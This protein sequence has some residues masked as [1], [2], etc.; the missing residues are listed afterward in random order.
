MNWQWSALDRFTLVSNSDAHSPQ[1]LGREA[2]LFDTDFS[3]DGLFNALKSQEGFLGTYEFFPEEGKYHLDGHRACGVTLEPKDTIR[4]K[5][6]C[7]VCGRPLTVGVL[8]RVEE[9]SDRPAPQKPEGSAGYEYLIPLPEILAE[10]KG[11]GPDSKAVM[12]AYQQTISAFGNE[13]TLLEKVPVEDIKRSGDPVLAEA[14]RRMRS[15]QVNPQPGFDGVYGVIR[16]FE[17]GELAK[18]S[19]Q[20]HLFGLV[21]PVP[22]EKADHAPALPEPDGL[23][24]T[25]SLPGVDGLSGTSN[26]SDANGLSGPSADGLSVLEEPLVTLKT[27]GLN[28]AQQQVKEAVTGAVLVK[29]GPGTGKTSTLIQWIGNQIGSGQARPSEV[30]AITFTNKAAREISERLAGTLGNDAGQITTDRKSV[31]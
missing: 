17:D 25:G 22:S 28:E 10:I 4:Y 7:P 9:L 11:S 3:Y 19:G 14:I 5:G 21:T 27:T 12:Q 31:V 29:A 15:Q 16:I 6:I 13:F 30:L 26:L 23:S 20:L 1:K 2:N 8:N 24:G 18:L